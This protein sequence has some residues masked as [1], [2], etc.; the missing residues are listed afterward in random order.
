[1]T[2]ADI[3]EIDLVNYLGTTLAIKSSNYLK[4]R[5]KNLEREGKAPFYMQ[6]LAAKM[7]YASIVN[8]DLFTEVFK[9]KKDF[10][11]DDA[12]LITIIIGSA[13]SGKTTAIVGSVI[14]D[15]RSTN[16]KSTI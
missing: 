2:P 13:G 8:P 11:R 1:M 3:E 14:D 5:R 6:E 16:P 10:Y 15:I 9:I 7:T 4:K 12:E